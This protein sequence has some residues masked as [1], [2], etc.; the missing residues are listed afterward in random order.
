MFCLILQGGMVVLVVKSGFLFCD[1]LVLSI[2]TNMD[3]LIKTFC[4]TMGGL[5]NVS[6]VVK[7]SIYMEI[8]Y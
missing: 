1:G 6:R 7:K 2:S 3:M 4:R 5:R 8:H